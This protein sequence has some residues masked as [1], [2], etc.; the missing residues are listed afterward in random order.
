MMACHEGKT[1]AMRVGLI[2]CLTV[3]AIVALAGVVAMFYKLP[4]AATAIT[5]GTALMGAGGFS[6]AIQ[7]R[8]EN[9]AK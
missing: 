2:T 3:G 8:Y 9:G 6:K 1:S 4:D 5:T 7:S